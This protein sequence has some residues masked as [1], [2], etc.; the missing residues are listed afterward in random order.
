MGYCA[1]CTLQMVF[2][3]V[4][5]DVVDGDEAESRTL[6]LKAPSEV[7]LDI[8]LGILD[9]RLLS[10]LAFRFGESRHALI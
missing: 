10:L 1:P 5:P 3:D 8:R 2:R 4:E 6:L 9:H 7:D